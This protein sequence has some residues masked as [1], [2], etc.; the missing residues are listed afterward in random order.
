[1]LSRQRLPGWCIML[2]DS[3]QM[4]TA[5]GWSAHLMLSG[6]PFRKLIA[7]QPDPRTTT[8]GLA[9]GPAWDVDALLAFVSC[10]G[11]SCSCRHT[12][13]TQSKAG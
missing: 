6:R 12:E 4:Q 10:C 8:R 7:P 5:P 9:G 11:S 1:M 3:Q 13:Q 2:A